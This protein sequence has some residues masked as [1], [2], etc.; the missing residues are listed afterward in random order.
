MPKMISERSVHTLL[1][2]KIEAL[3]KLLNN[4]RCKGMNRQ[5]VASQISALLSVKQQLRFVVTVE[6][7]AGAIDVDL[8]KLEIDPSRQPGGIVEGSL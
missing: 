7:N 8:R 1:D 4:P 6:T 3:D 2:G 5:I